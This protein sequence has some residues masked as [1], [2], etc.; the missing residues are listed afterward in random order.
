M[1]VLFTAK[2]S[3][4]V[5]S[6]VEVDERFVNQFTVII[7]GCLEGYQG[8]NVYPSDG[9]ARRIGVGIVGT[10]SAEEILLLISVVIV[11]VALIRKSKR[12]TNGGLEFAIDACRIWKLNAKKL[13]DVPDESLENFEMEL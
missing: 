11:S 9:E 4:S 7:S 1:L 13:G 5:W 8:G 12:D 3:T 10:P 2:K 6:H